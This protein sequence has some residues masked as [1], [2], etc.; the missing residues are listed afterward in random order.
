MTIVTRNG[1][2]IIHNKD[3]I[4]SFGINLIRNLQ[5]PY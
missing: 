4:N 5:N 1:K 3:I 2:D